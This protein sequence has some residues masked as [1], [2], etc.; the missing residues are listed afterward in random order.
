[1]RDL[2]LTVSHYSGV[3]KNIYGSPSHKLQIYYK[4]N[5]C[6]YNNFPLCKR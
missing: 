4:N 1:M 6:G 5:G 2:V 3:E